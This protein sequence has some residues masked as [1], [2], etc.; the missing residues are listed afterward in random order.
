M[1]CATIINPGGYDRAVSDKGLKGAE[2][3]RAR[4]W[5]DEA[6]LPSLSRPFEHRQVNVFR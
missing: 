3:D 5:T 2:D 6:Y 4:R 1:E